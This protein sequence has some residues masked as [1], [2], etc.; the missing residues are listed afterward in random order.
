MGGVL[1]SFRYDVF[2]G[3]LGLLSLGLGARQFRR[4]AQVILLRFDFEGL[5]LWVRALEFGSQG[6]EY[7]MLSLDGRLL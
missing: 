3:E 6:L 4:I 1:L 2:L 5:Q 7:R